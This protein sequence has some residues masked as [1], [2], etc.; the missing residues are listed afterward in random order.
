MSNRLIDNIII[1]VDSLQ[2]LDENIKIK[3]NDK[4]NS[5]IMQEPPKELIESIK[6]LIKRF[7][8]HS[9]NRL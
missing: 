8:I 6:K 9:E 1:G 2:Q 3:T 4:I 7:K 5:A